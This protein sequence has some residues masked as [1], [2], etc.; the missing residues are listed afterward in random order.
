VSR[1]RNVEKSRRQKRMRRARDEHA[2]I[3]TEDLSQCL[4]RVE[5]EDWEYAISSASGN[6]ANAAEALGIRG[7]P[8]NARVLWGRSEGEAKATYIGWQRKRKGK[9]A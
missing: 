9:T 6:P 7:V 8:R 5:R 4:A 3:F 2:F 1:H